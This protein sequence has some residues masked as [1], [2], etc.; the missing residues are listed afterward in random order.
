MTGPKRKKGN[1][2]WK[3]IHSLRWEDFKEWCVSRLPV[4]EWLPAYNWKADLIPDIVSGMMLAVQQVMQGW[5][6][7][8]IRFENFESGKS[9]SSRSI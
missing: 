4:L 1:A 5:Y 2:S 7:V 6:C 9:Y 8:E 3:K